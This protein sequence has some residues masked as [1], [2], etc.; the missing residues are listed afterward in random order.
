[1]RLNQSS[2]IVAD[3]TAVVEGLTLKAGTRV[4]FAAEGSLP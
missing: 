4:M 1:M 2:D 3:A